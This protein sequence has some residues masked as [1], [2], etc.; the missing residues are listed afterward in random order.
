MAEKYAGRLEILSLGPLTDVA[1]ALQKSPEAAKKI[2][3]VVVMGGGIHAGNATKYAEFN[4]V[5]DPEAAQV[6]FSSGVKA[7]MPMVVCFIRTFTRFLGDSSSVSF[8]R[9]QSD[10]PYTISAWSSMELHEVI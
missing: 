5:A 2:A 7:G 9:L 10:F 8:S 6:V 4:I 1:L 3:R